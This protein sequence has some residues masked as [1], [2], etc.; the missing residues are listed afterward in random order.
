MNLK[1]HQNLFPRKK[2]RRTELENLEITLKGWNLVKSVC[3]ALPFTHAISQK[4]QMP[5]EINTADGYAEGDMGFNR[6]GA[7]EDADF[8]FNF[9]IKDKDFDDIYLL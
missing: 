2:K 3:Q 6:E 4:N 8:E 9:V 5:V 1:I 7:N